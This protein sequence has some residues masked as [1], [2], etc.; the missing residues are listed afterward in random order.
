MVGEDTE[1]L[2]QKFMDFIL[3]AVLDLQQ[4]SMESTEASNIP[5]VHT[6]A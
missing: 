4:N 2:K 6:Q 5:P 1:S 3:G